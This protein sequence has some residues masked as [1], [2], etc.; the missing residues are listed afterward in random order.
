MVRSI[1][2]SACVVLCAGVLT[3]MPGLGATGV[4]SAQVHVGADVDTTAWPQLGFDSARTGF[5]PSESTLNPRR[6]RTL[7]QSW[8]ALSGTPF[9][10]SPAIVGDV[11]YVGDATAQGVFRAIDTGTGETQWSVALGN[12]IDSSPAVSGSLVYVGTRAESG[13]SFYALNLADGSIAWSRPL[14]VIDSSPTVVDGTV[15]VG[16]GNHTFYALDAS[17]GSTKWS[18]VTGSFVT[19]SPAVVGNRVYVG[20]YEGQVLAF[21]ATSGGSVAGGFSTRFAVQFAP[22]V[23]A[24]QIFA[25]DQ[26]YLYA[27]NASSGHILWR[28]RHSNILAPP[29]VSGSTLYLELYP[30]SGGSSSL[31]AIDA[32]TGTILWKRKIAQA[33]PASPSVADGVVYAGSLQGLKASTGQTIWSADLG[34]SRS[35]AVSSG[36]I[37]VGGDGLYAFAPSSP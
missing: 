19:S 3:L 13:D 37:Y 9:A 27:A 5:N 2:L 36:R 4:S 18:H 6:A 23:A 35:V 34:E 16:S 25:V 28:V 32:G 10:S 7:T 30:P 1:R 14:G 20:S 21:D 15:Y 24:G 17:S 29:A 12:V 31:L 22:V 33:S 26:K 11:L 8:N